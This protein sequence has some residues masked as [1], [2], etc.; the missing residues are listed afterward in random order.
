MFAL[1]SLALNG[2]TFATSERVRRACEFLLRRQM[3]DGGWGE[4]YKVRPL[5]PLSSDRL[6][7]DMG[8]SSRARRASTSTT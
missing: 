6:I 5:S 7:D 1:E 4:S 8:P 2:E 3:D